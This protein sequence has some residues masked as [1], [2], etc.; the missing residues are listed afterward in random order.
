[1]PT[2]TRASVKALPPYVLAEQNLPGIAHPILLAQNEL[3]APPSPRAVAAAGTALTQLN[4]YPN[5]DHLSL[6]EA[7]AQVHGLSSE[8]LLCGAGSMELLGLLA[9]C[10]CEPGAEMVMT[11]FGYK[12]FQLQCTLAGAQIHVVPE[13]DMTADVPAIAAAVT[14]ATRLV[15]VV[16]PNNPTGALLAPGEV[17][18]L[19]ALLPEHVLLVLDCAYAEFVSGQAYE[20]GFDLVDQG[21]N[22]VVLRTFSKAYGLAGLRIGWLYG[23]ADVV[24]ALS[25]ARPPNSVTTPGLA[26]AQAAVEDQDHLKC[27]VAEVVELRQALSEK[28]TTLGLEPRPSQGNFL[29]IGCP[30][31]GP[32]SAHPLYEG[33]KKSGIV[34]R[35][36]T[37]YDL[38]HHLRVT[39]GSRAEM[40]KF[41]E[42]LEK[43]L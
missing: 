27:A 4:R 7:I 15:F 2:P 9:Q 17:A 34:V 43:L 14:E 21:A 20:N 30:E 11:Q 13:N 39:I 12:F 1:M 25:A 31:A 28:A 32:L 19:R 5:P 10:Y 41:D 6:R 29:L 36:M 26:A 24:A 22:I 37:S 33:L 42:A 18:R 23:P 16:N 40:T 8:R 3:G 38:P 35:P